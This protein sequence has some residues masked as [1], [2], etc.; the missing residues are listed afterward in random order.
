MRFLAILLLLAAPAFAFEYEPALPDAAQEK[1]A[2][3]IFAVVRCLVCDGESL[4]SSAADYSVSMRAMIR[5]QIAAGKSKD[6]VLQYLT[7]RYGN[8]VL[9]SPPTHGGGLLLWLMPLLLLII[10]AIFMRRKR[11]K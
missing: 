5:E 9:Q 2:H 8:A 6:E 3:E 4:A 10:G 1:T 7:Y 11:A